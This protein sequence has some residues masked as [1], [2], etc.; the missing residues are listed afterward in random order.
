MASVFTLHAAKASSWLW[1]PSLINLEAQRLMRKQSR[2][3]LHA[4]LCAV[5]GPLSPYFSRANFMR[6]LLMSVGLLHGRACLSFQSQ[7][8]AQCVQRTA[9]QTA[10]EHVRSA[11]DVVL[12]S[13]HASCDW[14]NSHM[15]APC[16]NSL[17]SAR[18]E[19][20]CTAVGCQHERHASPLE[21][22]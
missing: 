18:A 15:Y 13:L 5:S 7:Q 14:C 3:S 16:N 8:S 9:V 17:E 11:N 21:C 10:A 2:R 12:C 22:R 19:Q 1:Q 6:T 20:A 4:S